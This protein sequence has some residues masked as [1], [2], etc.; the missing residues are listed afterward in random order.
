[1]VSA[2]FSKA[3]G[4]EMRAD[5]PAKGVGRNVEHQRERYLSPDE[6]ERLA[7]Q[8]E[9]FRGKGK[10]WVDST[11]EIDLARLTG[12][13]RGEILQMTWAQI[14][15]LDGAAVWVLPSRSTKEGKHTGISKRLPLSDSAAAILRRRRDE[16][17]ATRG[18]V[19]RLR[20]PKSVDDDRVFRSGADM[21]ERDWR[22]IRA[23]AGLS[24]VRFHDL[25]HSFASTLVSA[26][27]SLPIIGKL[28]GHSTPQMTHRYSHLSDSPLRAA[29]EIAAKA[30]K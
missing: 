26:G 14:E 27:L 12:A 21:L 17:A 30:K 18:N 5:N 1:L 24:D 4:W 11:D 19:V 22:V 29:V 3:I 23:A 28:L 20:A 25:R 7:Q 6:D 8:I 13:R 10:H 15:N 2:I 9:I 16:R